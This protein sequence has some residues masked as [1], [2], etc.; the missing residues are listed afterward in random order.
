MA[1]VTSDVLLLTFAG[2]KTE[3]D[4]AYILAQESARWK[5]IADE[6]PTTLPIQNYA[7]LG[8]GAVM[9]PF[10]DEVEEQSVR[11]NKYTLA[12]ITYKGNL[13]VDRRTI[14]D[15]QYGLIM[16]RA[17]GLAAEPTR[18]WN[19]LAFTGLGTG[20]ANLCYDGLSFFNANHQEG[21]S[22]VQSN[23]TNASLSDA[24]LQAAEAQ[25]MA[26]VDDKGKPLEVMPNTLV[27]GP[28]NKRKA[29]DLCGSAIVV[30]RVGDGAAGAGA[31]AST[32]FDNYFRGKYQVVVS[33]YLIGATA[34]NWFLAD[35][36][37]EEKPIVIQ[38]RQD[39]PITLETD[40][41]Q[42]SAKIAEKYNVTIRGRYVQGYGLWQLAWGSNASS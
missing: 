12:D 26:Y 18:H 39:V 34:Y 14:E 8:R 33:P 6:I 20:F 11:E 28:A 10:V 22:P 29:E 25:M 19:E 17:R 30:T 36:S 9:K 32:P 24:A 3:F 31:T 21:V 41:D 23:V 16:K 35:T 42:P 38:S 4:A 37:R 7:W 5:L 2:I 1:T 13:A 27:V 40:M 15:D